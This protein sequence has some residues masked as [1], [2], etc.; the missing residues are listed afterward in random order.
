M[1]AEAECRPFDFAQGRQIFGQFDGL[2]GGRHI[3]HNSRACQDTFCVCLDNAF[4]DAF[5]KSEVIGVYYQSFFH[6]FVG[7]ALAH[8]A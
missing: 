6:Y 7:W 8:R 2:F 4:V 3:G 5:A 1:D